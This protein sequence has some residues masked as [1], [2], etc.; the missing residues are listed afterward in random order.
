LVAVI[1]KA[2]AIIIVAKPIAR[3]LWYTFN[4]IATSTFQ[5]SSWSTYNLF[6]LSKVFIIHT[7]FTK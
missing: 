3:Y 7:S 1:A 6:L 4:F 2:S 5:L